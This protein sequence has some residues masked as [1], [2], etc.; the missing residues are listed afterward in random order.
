MS[1][2]D[3]SAISDPNRREIALALQDVN[4]QIDLCEEEIS[5][6]SSEIDRLTNHADGLDY[7]VAVASGTITALIDS[8]FGD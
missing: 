2:I 4:K 6:L 1:P 5:K 7:A 8:F 3:I